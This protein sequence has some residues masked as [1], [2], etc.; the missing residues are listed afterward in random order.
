L[1]NEA[2]HLATSTDNQKAGCF[3]KPIFRYRLPP[4]TTKKAEIKGGHIARRHYL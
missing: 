3:I 1:K 2:A 4:I